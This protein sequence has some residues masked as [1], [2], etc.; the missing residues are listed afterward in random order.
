MSTEF[1][2]R[3]NGEFVANTTLAGDQA[4]PVMRKLSSGGFVLV[5]EDQGSNGDPADFDLYGQVFDSNGAKVGAQFLVSTWSASLQTDAAITYLPSGGFIVSWTDYSG[6]GGDSTDSSVK[7]QRFTDSGVQ[8]GGEFLVN[9][10]T[11]GSESRPSLV[12]LANGDVLFTY[13]ANSAI[14]GRL[15]S[16]ASSTL[17]SQ[18][19][20]TAPVNGPLVALTDGRLATATMSFDSAQVRLFNPDGSVA[21][22]MITVPTGPPVGTGTLSVALSATPGGGFAIVWQNPSE[23]HASRYDSA[24]NPVGNIQLVTTTTNYTHSDPQIVGLPNGGYVVSWTDTSQYG[25]SE[26][27]VRAQAFDSGGNKAGTEFL[28]STQTDHPNQ[29]HGQ[30]T[31]EVLASGELVAAWHG[32]G[33]GDER[34]PD[35]SWANADGGIRVQMYSP[36][37]AAPVAFDASTLTISE[38]AVQNV[39]AIEFIPQKEPVNGADSYTILSDSTGGAF[40]IEG[41]NLVVADNS[42]LDYEAHHTATVTVRATDPAGNVGDRTFTIQIADSAVEPTLLAA[43]LEVRANSL[44]ANHQTRPTVAS[45]G[46]G[47]YV[48][49]WGSATGNASTSGIRGQVFDAANVKVGGEFR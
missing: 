9:A 31:L 12:T 2:T 37:G 47:G 15:Y 32:S 49:I 10:T 4:N 28:V 20:F 7:A 41:D 44:T 16:T 1:F 36:I 26:R 8:V 3:H 6:Q 43:G 13:Y 11:G 34:A 27:V 38:L 24:G 22:P 48:A 21:A 23:I 29:N 14:V 18:F 42:K 19:S 39:A 5:W 25:T 33:P 46:A 17:G 35:S 30:S 40:R 45:L